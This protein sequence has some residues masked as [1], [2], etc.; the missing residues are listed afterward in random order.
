MWKE[1]GQCWSRSRIFRV[2]LVVSVLYTVFRLG[3]H[4]ALLASLIDRGTVQ[5]DKEYLWRDLQVYMDAA[6][7][8]QARQNLYPEKET[9]L[10]FYQYAP[11]YLLTCIPLIRL[12]FMT[13][14]Q[15]HSLLHILA[16]CW[17]YVLW[18]RIFDRLGLKRANEMMI[19]TLPVWLLFW[20]FWNDLNA[21]NIGTLMAFL[22][23]LLIDAILKE[24]LV[25]SVVWLAVILQIKPQWAFAAAVPLL[26]G[27][28]RFF[29]KLIAWTVVTYLCMVGLTM[30][31]AGFPYVWQQ[32]MGYFNLLPRIN[33]DFVWRTPA[34][35]PFLGFNH[36]IMQTV[37]FLLGVSP[38]TFWMTTGIKIVLLVPLAVVSLRHLLR[39]IRQAAWMAPQKSLDIAFVMYLAAFIW[40]DMIWELSLGMAVFVYLLAVLERLWQQVSVWVVFLSMALTEFWQIVSLGLFGMRVLSSTSYIM[41]SPSVYVPTIMIVILVFYTFLVKRLWTPR[42]A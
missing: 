32:Y 6:A 13:V 26:L 23:T 22:A 5:G 41:T 31:I 36:S 9:G 14:V 4:V 39:P 11:F 19:W 16:Y 24:H 21:L 33:R 30:C 40:L 38:I 37:Y 17:T 10:Y 25:G 35:M 12:P 1:L 2:I 15:I 18:W 7:R 27:Q 29:I 20:S 3:G 28:Y 8:F 34:D 42:L